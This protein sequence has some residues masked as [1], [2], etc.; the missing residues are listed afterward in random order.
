MHQHPIIE[1]A[2][3]LFLAALLGGLVGWERERHERPAGLRTHILVCVGAALIAIVD[4][5]GTNG[6]GRI[7]AQIVTGIGFLGAG[8]IMRDNSGLVRGLTT[9]ASVW[10][11]AG[12]GI[13]IGYGGETAALAAVATGIVLITLTVLN[14][15]ESTL[16]RERKRQELNL[17]LAT[18]DDAL[19]RM[20][21]LLDALRE[22]GTRTRDI[23]FSQAPDSLIVRLELVMKRNTNRDD[24]DELLK[25]RPEVIHFHWTE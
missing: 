6:G 25:K 23:S 18:G 1:L 24:L 11:V 20:R 5:T 9:A 8:C 2:A 19:S 14:R 21:A 16:N 12:L 17:V 4:R 22:H 15:L 10:V 13:A 7:A 3:L